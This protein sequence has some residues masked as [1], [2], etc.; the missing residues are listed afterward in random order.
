METEQ[1]LNS[2]WRFHLGDCPDAWQKW[3]KDESWEQVDLPHDW[4]VT[5]PFSRSCS[6]GTGYLEG[7]IGWYRLTLNPG[8]DFDPK[9]QSCSLLFEGIYKNAQI[10]VNSYYLGQRP[11]GY[12]PQ[13]YDISPFVDPGCSLEISVRVDHQDIAD[14]RWFTGSGIY[15]PVKLLLRPL[16][17]LVHDGVYFH[18]TKVSAAKAEYVIQAEVANLSQQEQACSLNTLLKP[19]PRGAQPDGPETGASSAV[20]SS[21]TL[22]AGETRTIT[23][24][25][26]V[27][28]PLLWQPQ[29]PWL[30]DLTLELKSPDFQSQTQLTVGLST[31]EFS[32]DRGLL[33]NG[34]PTKLKGVCV[35]HDAG[36]LGAA[37]YPS[38]WLRRLE[39]LK[40][41]GCNAIRMSHNPHLPQLYE[42]CDRLGFL[43][44]DEIF[45]EWEGPKNK[46]S[47]GHNVYPPKHQGYYEAYPDWH[48]RDVRD[49]VRRDRNHPSVIAWSV[50]NEIDYPNDPYCHPEF[51]SMTGNNDANKPEAERQYNP[52][53][54]NASRLAA[55]ASDLARLVQQEDPYRPATIAA[56]FPELSSQVGFLEPFSLV[57]YNYKEQFYDQDHQRFPDKT[58]VG[59]ENAHSYE[60]WQA[61]QQRPYVAGQFLWTGIDYLGEAPGWPVHGSAAGLLTLAGF[62][63]GAAYFRHSLWAKEPVL[64]LLTRA[65]DATEEQIP[66]IITHDYRPRRSWNYRPGQKVLVYAFTNQSQLSLTLNG[67]KLEA[68]AKPDPKIGYLAWVL[69][70]Q[71]GTLEAAAFAKDSNTAVVI[72]RLETSGPAVG[73]KLTKWQPETA[74][75]PSAAM[76]DGICQV[77]VQVC[78]ALGN[79]VTEGRV[80]VH[81]SVAGPGK[82]LGLENGDLADYTDYQAQYRSSFG[83]H[84]IA[85]VSCT[86]TESP[87]SAPVILTASTEEWGSFSLRL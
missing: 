80:R 9:T 14:S 19:E 18:C 58:F 31:L 11:N 47:T 2:G 45:D 61:D 86:A 64:H 79:P 30:Y 17:Q 49:W 15:R 39:T 50:G 25:G 42:L 20:T 87:S 43:V 70:Y 71:A 72:D 13:Y 66:E 63:K 82:L 59:S 6:S 22:A 41:L 33:L 74:L 7:G 23:L 69:D 65:W 55:L 57:G 73:L 8:P 37:V 68:L 5:Q 34:H 1:Y 54:P 38:V 27:Q 76:S 62:K 40:S 10:W 36:C 60:A 3:Y 52:D 24:K 21:F 4:S 26:D 32:P 56:A 77:E 53:R 16:L 29:T 81:V 78:D 51:Q 67:R 46:W 28:A 12:I 83:G 35:H 48:A 44:M 75:S 85:Y 84:L